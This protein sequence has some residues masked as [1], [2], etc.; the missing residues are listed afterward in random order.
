MRI[1][2]ERLALRPLRLDDIDE[3]LDMH[4]DPDVARYMTSFDRPQAVARLEQ[5]AREW[6]EHGRGLIAIED[7][8]TGHFLGRAAL[9]FWPQF[10]ETELGWVLRRD[11]WGH[12]YATE[13]AT[14]CADWG[15]ANLDIPYL[16]A[17]IRPANARSIAV[18]RRLDMTPLRDDVHSEI[19]VIVYS[20]TREHWGRDRVGRAPRLA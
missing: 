13:A 15:F 2:T 17:M 20:I 9:K 14:A 12:G 7:R 6:S 3:L 4:A 11:V 19:P 18:A 16:T 8:R 5:D 10:D 1:E